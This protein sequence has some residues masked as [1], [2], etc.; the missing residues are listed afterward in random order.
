[1]Q[2]I[3]RRFVSVVLLILCGACGSLPQN[4]SMNPVPIQANEKIQ[5]GM[6][7]VLVGITGPLGVDYLQF[8]HSSMPAIN[9]RFPARG[10]EIVAVAVPVGL[11]R[12]SLQ[13]ITIAGRPGFYLPTGM[14]FGYV[15]V[16]TPRIEIDRPGIYYVATLDTATPGKF[17]EAPLPEQLVRYR[18]DSKET[19][20][21]LEPINFRWPQ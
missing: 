9:V 21:D 17:T 4:F 11:K 1:M 3:I 6:A 19:I 2:R 14:S 10:N 5:N 20:G 16:N 8:V 18:Q 13:T 15:G 7:I 12:V